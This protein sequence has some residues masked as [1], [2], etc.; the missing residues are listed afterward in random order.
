MVVDYPVLRV[1]ADLGIA[2]TYTSLGVPCRGAKLVSFHLTAT[3]GNAPQTYTVQ[4]RKGSG[5]WV[6]IAATTGAGARATA[7]AVGPLNAGGQVIQL[8]GE[9]VTSGAVGGG[10]IASWDEARIQVLGHA[11]LSITGLACTARVVLDGRGEMLTNEAI[12]A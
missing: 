1:A 4:A 10:H 11:T 2:A 6:T 9:L 8:G 3:N 5:S 7:P 12:T